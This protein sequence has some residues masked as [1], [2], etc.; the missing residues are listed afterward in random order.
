MMLNLILLRAAPAFTQ[1]AATR[2]YVAS[3]GKDSHIGTS[4]EPLATL[5]KAVDQSRAIRGRQTLKAPIEILV[6]QGKYFLAALI[7]L[8]ARCKYPVSDSHFLLNFLFHQRL[9]PLKWGQIAQS[10]VRSSLIIFFD[11]FGC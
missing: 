4:E 6:K 5:A 9:L 11:P 7:M 8:D 3:D 2:I 1:S 10:F